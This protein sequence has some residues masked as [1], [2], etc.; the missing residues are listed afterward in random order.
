MWA[1]TDINKKRM[2]LRRFL[3]QKIGRIPLQ[4]RAGIVCMKHLNKV[5]QSHF[6]VAF[7]WHYADIIGHIC[8]V[9]VN[10]FV[11]KD[12]KNKSPTG[13]NGHLSIRYTAF[14]SY[15]HISSPI[16]E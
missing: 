15:L 12:E 10:A 3:L 5:I 13:L 16:I 4:K 7:Y 1:F 14:L 8:S 6:L 11:D 2:S 9:N